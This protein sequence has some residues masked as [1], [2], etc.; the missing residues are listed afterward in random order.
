MDK[1]QKS[2]DSRSLFH[3]PGY[4]S[5]PLDTLRVTK[6]SPIYFYRKQ[7]HCRPALTGN[8]YKFITRPV[9]MHLQ[10][11]LPNKARVYLSLWTAWV[12][13]C[14]HASISHD[15]RGIL[16]ARNILCT[17]WN[18]E[19]ANKRI[20]LTVHEYLAE[21]KMNIR[22]LPFWISEDKNGVTRGWYCMNRF[23]CQVRFY[24][25]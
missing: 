14:V 18:K 6:Q 9:E 23:L 24:V 10:Q 4:R 16:S 3:L 12:Y 22:G 8:I 5:R 1:I 17:E 15:C 20:F 21:P 19:R 13:V 25:Y 11:R 2:T 7:R